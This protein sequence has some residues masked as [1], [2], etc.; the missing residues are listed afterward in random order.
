MSH[1]AILSAQVLAVAAKR[2]AKSLVKTQTDI[3][4]F[5]KRVDV[6]RDRI[7]TW[8]SDLVVIAEHPSIFYDLMSEQLLEQVRVCGE[9]V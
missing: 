6:T 2:V 1:E 3:E 4:R 7:A 5:G 8:P 9:L